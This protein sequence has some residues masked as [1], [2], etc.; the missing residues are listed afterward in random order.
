LGVPNEPPPYMELSASSPTRKRVQAS[1]AAM[2]T[3]ERPRRANAGVNK[4]YDL[5]EAAKEEAPDL[6]EPNDAGEEDEGSVAGPS[7]VVDFS[8]LSPPALMRYVKHYNIAVPES[9]DKQALVAA[10]EAH[11]CVQL[12]DEREVVS[13]FLCANGYSPG[14]GPVGG[15]GRRSYDTPI[16]KANT[17]RR[18]PR[19]VNGTGGGGDGGGYKPTSRAPT[20]GDMISY[21][22]S[23]L[24]SNQGTLD[25]ICDL[26]EVKYAAQLNQEMES[27]PRRIPVWKASVRKIINLNY[28]M[29][30][31]R[32]V[33]ANGIKAVFSFASGKR[34]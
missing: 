32:S 7:S 13:S 21:A 34:R 3:S 23:Q 25:E 26:I 4:V 22:L 16:K 31:R 30:F 33:A 24:P 20:Y 9:C 11:F 2:S 10:V 19:R 12:V 27:G 15:S 1:A 14:L 8:L 5:F 28:G 18:V 6:D 29:R 17:T